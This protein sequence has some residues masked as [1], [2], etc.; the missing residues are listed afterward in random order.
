[1]T[2]PRA[3]RWRP[4][5]ALVAALAFSAGALWLAVAMHRPDLFAIGAPPLCAVAAD[6]LRIPRGTARAT[7][8][9]RPAIL[10]EGQ[11]TS[12]DVLA[13][14]DDSA[15]LAVVR[16]WPGRH[17]EGGPACVVSRPR[18][19]LGVRVGSRAVRWGRTRSGSAT[20]TL[21]AGHGLFRLSVPASDAG[22]KIVPLREPFE[23]VDA[24]P[25]TS[26]VVGGHRS[27]RP[28]EGSDLAT[29]RPFLPGDR[30][31]RI[32]WPVSQRTGTLHVTATH[33][34]QDTAIIIVIDSAVD[35]GS[36]D[37][38]ETGGNLD[39]A[40]HAAASVA[41][42]YL[43]HGDRVGLIDTARP[44]RP[45]RPAAGRKHLDRIVEHLLDLSATRAVREVELSRVIARMQQRALVILLSPLIA[46]A[47]PELAAELALAGLHVLVID[48]LGTEPPSYLEGESGELAYRM[49]LLRR[50][51]DID[52]LAELGV[53]VVPWRGG[54]SLD[55]VLR[56]V[57]R[58][59]R[60]PRVRA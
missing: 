56:S 50:Q 25:H 42:F 7:V 33:A 37:A 49:T 1:V 14:I 23:A 18:S 47:R 8:R 43:R 27:R 15:D 9:A 48:T 28:G 53:P 52:R 21:S 2:P 46:P 29:I 30:L 22:V 36:R 55:D 4:T 26:G 39:V 41:E 5:P 17:L 59:A 51:V 24:V 10:R 32:N 20:V 11:E 35:V 12:L 60:T 31:R 3:V 19:P 58:A 6:A 38:T 44:V 16:L 40:V 13:E 54:N 45:I 34:E 57:A